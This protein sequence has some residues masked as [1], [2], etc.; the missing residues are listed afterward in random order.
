[1]SSVAGAAPAGAVVSFGSGAGPAP[2]EALCFFA[3]GSAAGLT[4]PRA[5]A[6]FNGVTTAVSDR[7][8]ISAAA[9]ATAAALT[10]LILWA[11]PPLPFLPL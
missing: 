5:F 10:F 1:M 8:C 11:L 4:P 2:A 3:F 9:L 7:A 6:G